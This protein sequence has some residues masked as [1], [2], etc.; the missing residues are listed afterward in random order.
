MPN[1]DYTVCFFYISLVP[2]FPL[3]ERGHWALRSVRVTL[4]FLYFVLNLNFQ[5]HFLCPL[6]IDLA[7]KHFQDILP[8]SFKMEEIW[9]HV[10][11]SQE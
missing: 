8:T 3:S 9:V 4:L 10:S 2:T 6:T 7:N 11:S 5:N 1:N